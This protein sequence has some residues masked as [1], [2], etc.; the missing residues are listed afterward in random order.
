MLER[1]KTP[2]KDRVRVTDN[3]LRHTITSIFEKMG[4]THEDALIAAE[5]LVSAELRGIETHGVSMVANYIRQYKEGLLCPNPDWK[6]VRETPGTATIDAG[7][8]LAVFLGQKAMMMAIEKAKK[9]GVGVIAIGN[10]GHSGPIGHHALLAAKKDMIGIVMTAC[11]LLVVPT[12]GA[13]PRMGTNPI[14]F[15]APSRNE[16]PFLFDAATS[17]IAGQKRDLA[18]RAQSDLLPYWFAEKDGTPITH[19]MPPPARDKFLLPLGGVRESGSHKGYGF[20]M[21]PEILGMLLSGGRPNMLT[22][23][24][25]HA[26]HFTAYN[27]EAFTDLEIFK[28]GMDDVLRTLRTTKP[29]PGHN[30][31]L[32][33]GLAEYEEEKERKR[34]GVPLHLEIV[35][36]FEHISDQLSVPGLDRV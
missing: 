31:V 33:A 4:E 21:M 9:V 20:A 1:F 3:S 18:S 34:N 16:A 25:N 29:A 24:K 10:S 17:M 14:A 7:L 30:R 5:V 12:F 32:Y 11:P 19:E 13:D 23:D 22:G 6:I 35:Q 27:V 8:G 26:H 36:W 28:D 2:E 15:S